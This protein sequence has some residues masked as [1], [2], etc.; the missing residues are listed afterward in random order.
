MLWVLEDLVDIFDEEENRQHNPIRT[1]LQTLLAHKLDSS[2]LIK[3][4]FICIQLE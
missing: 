4:A 2:R 1:T 3:L